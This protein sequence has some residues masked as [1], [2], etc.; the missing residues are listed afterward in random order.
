MGDR[1][2]ESHCHPV[3]FRVPC[4]VEIVVDVVVV[5]VVVG[6]VGEIDSHRLVVVVV[7]GVGVDRLVGS[8]IGCIFVL[9]GIGLWVG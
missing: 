2:V 6:S 8:L 3:V 4:V 7:V 5:A 1:F 9:S